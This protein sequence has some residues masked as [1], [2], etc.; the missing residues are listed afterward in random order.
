MET[1]IREA[2]LNDCPELSRL[3]T[4]LGYPCSSSVIHSNLTAWGDDPDQVVFVSTVG[5]GYLLGFCHAFI[6]K[7]LFLAPFAELGGLVVDER[8]RGEGTGR[9]LVD[10]FERWAAE[11][12]IKEIRVRSNIIRAGAWEFYTGLGYQD[13]KKQTVFLKDLD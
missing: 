9:K 4:Q 5:E 2:D 7:R 10:E 13:S 11:K 1:I 12:G 3:S 6:S 8:F